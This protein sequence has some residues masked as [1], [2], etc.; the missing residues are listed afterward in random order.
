MNYALEN[1]YRACGHSVL[2]VCS[3]LSCM[4]WAESSLDL[5]T[6]NQSPFRY[7]SPGLLKVFALQGY[8]K[9]GDLRETSKPCLWKR[10]AGWG[11]P[12]KNRGDRQVSL[13]AL[14]HHLSFSHTIG[15]E[16]EKHPDLENHVM[17]CAKLL[18]PL[19][20]WEDLENARLRGK[21]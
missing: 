12:P 17:S 19:Q 8:G 9:G 15:T 18:G 6:E 4:R 16:T 1:V 21:F 7:R 13:E 2:S 3:E 11:L 10:L 5:P 20:L 14:C